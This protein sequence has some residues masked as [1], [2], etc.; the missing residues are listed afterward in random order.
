MRC[1]SGT[2]PGEASGSAVM[3]RLCG[4]RNA[5][6]AVDG[7]EGCSAEDDAVGELGDGDRGAVV[8]GERGRLCRQVAVGIGP[9]SSVGRRRCR[10][11]TS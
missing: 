9:R 11:R 6:T 3:V 7:D 5:D 10:S 4:V 1:W 8:D 2:R